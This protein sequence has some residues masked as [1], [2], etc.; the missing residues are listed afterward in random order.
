MTAT[1]YTKDALDWFSHDVN[2]TSDQRFEYLLGKYPDHGYEIYFRLLERIFSNSYYLKWEERDIV[3]FAASIRKDFDLVKEVVGFCVDEGLFNKAIYNKYKILTS[4][5]IQKRYS[6]VARRRKAVRIIKEIWLRSS[7]SASDNFLKAAAYM[8]INDLSEDDSLDNDNDDMGKP[9]AQKP[10]V[11]PKSSKAIPVKDDVDVDDKKKATGI[12]KDEKR[13]HLAAK[14]KAQAREVLDYLN[15]K[16]GRQ[17]E[18][19]EN[20]VARINN[21]ATVAKCKQVIDV[22]MHDPYYQQNP[23]YYHPSTLFKKSKWDKHVNQRISDFDVKA[24]KDDASKDAYVESQ[25]R[26]SESRR[27]EAMGIRNEA[28]K[29]YAMA[30]TDASRN[31]FLKKQQEADRDI[32][33]HDIALRKLKGIL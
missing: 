32:K 24:K 4:N 30:T 19:I 25:I 5:G 27:D 23:S 9:G 13:K 31:R 17:F 22:K 28:R 2:P 7:S 6:V 10:S 29:N 15:E 8:S 1:V 21:G 33:R 11:V 12:S 3:L 14:R 16:V 26:E 18:D 20:I